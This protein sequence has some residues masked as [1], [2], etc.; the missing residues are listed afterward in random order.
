MTYT[1]CRGGVSLSTKWEV[2]KTVSHTELKFRDTGKIR[3]RREF[4]DK[5][6]FALP[7]KTPDYTWLHLARLY[8]ET[9]ENIMWIYSLNLDFG[10]INKILCMPDHGFPRIIAHLFIDR[11]RNWIV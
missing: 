10:Y 8:M 9:G 7:R 4:N 1:D 11:G 5:K 2:F 3:S 6:M